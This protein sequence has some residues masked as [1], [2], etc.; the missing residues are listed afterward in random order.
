[1]FGS[2]AT[3]VVNNNGTLSNAVTIGAAPTSPGVFSLNASGL[4]DAAIRHADST[5]VGPGNPAKANE[6]VELFLSGL[7]TLSTPVLDGNGATAIDNAITPVS[8]LVNGVASPKLYYQGLSVDAGLYQINF[9]VPPGTPSGE[10]TVTVVTPNAV[11][12]TG[13]IVVQ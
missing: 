11:T 1:L 8:I 9:T 2:T 6:I 13:T 5:V 3:I 4:G 7:G 12:K 10:Q